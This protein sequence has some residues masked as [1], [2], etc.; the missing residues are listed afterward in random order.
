MPTGDVAD[1][2]IETATRLFYAR[3][4][5]AS[6]VDTIAQAAGVSKPSLYAHFGDKGGLVRAVLA[7]QHGLRRR[8]LEAHLLARAGLP[9]R[10]RLLAV[11][12]WISTMQRGD[13]ARGCPFVNASVELGEGG[14]DSA[15]EVVGRHKL[16][17]RGMLAD[18]AAQAGARDPDRLASAL[19]LLIEGANARLLAEADHAA[20]DEARRS[21]EVLLA[22]A[23]PGESGAV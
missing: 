16:W 6:G 19:H 7:H 21:A 18:L 11:F 17:F 20:I 22:A 2:L 9:A 14:D 23:L 1:R 3:G 10:E 15:R 5:T 4:I 8:S 12:D 13:W